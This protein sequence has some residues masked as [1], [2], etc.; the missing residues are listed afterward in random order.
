MKNI[1]KT[2]QNAFLSWHLYIF[3]NRAETWYTASTYPSAKYNSLIRDMDEKPPKTLFYP[4]RSALMKHN[5]SRRSKL[6]NL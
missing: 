6:K 4:T 2:T 1:R 5:F 3:V